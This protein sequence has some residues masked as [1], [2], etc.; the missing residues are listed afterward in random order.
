MVSLTGFNA[1]EIRPL[2]DMEPLPNGDYSVVIT[3]SE[4]KSNKAGT[5]HYIEIVL[6]V[7]DGEYRGRRVFDRLNLWTENQIA[8]DIAN[9]RLSS[10]CRAVGVMT[11]RD[12]ADLHGIP[13]VVRIKLEK[14]KDDETRMDMR[15]AGYMP[16]QT[17]AAAAKAKGKQSEGSPW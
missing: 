6:E 16:R 7:T 5:G 1:A 17:A 12:T 8:R 9:S 13:F 10:I 11:P 3:S 14:R 4:K 2:G 15:I